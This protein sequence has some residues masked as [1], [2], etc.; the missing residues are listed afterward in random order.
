VNIPNLVVRFAGVAIAAPA[1]LGLAACGEATEA[2]QPT[3]EAAIP[4]VSDNPSTWLTDQSFAPSVHGLDGVRMDLKIPKEEVLQQ[5][6]ADAVARYGEI[7]TVVLTKEYASQIFGHYGVFIYAPM[8]NIHVTDG[9]NDV[10][11]NAGPLERKGFRYDQ[12]TDGI[13]SFVKEFDS[14]CWATI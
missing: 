10:K 6:Q 2:V 9:T 7:C 1:M 8:V 13:N 12:D 3:G 5:K 14:T 4:Y 11:V